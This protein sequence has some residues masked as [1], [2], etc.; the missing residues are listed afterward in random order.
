MGFLDVEGIGRT[1]QRTIEKI[2]EAQTANQAQTAN[3]ESSSR[4][5]ELRF[6]GAFARFR[7]ENNLAVQNVQ[8]Q[9]PPVD[10]DKVETVFN[11]TIE[12]DDLAVRLSDK[13][14][15]LNAAEKLQLAAMA[16]RSDRAE[17]LL[18]FFRPASPPNVTYD[19]QKQLATSIGAAYRQGI[20]TDSDLRQLAQR[21]GPEESARFAATLAQSPGNVNVGGVVEAYGRQA[22]ALGQSQA[23][24]LAFSSSE[25]LIRKDLPTYAD[26]SAAFNQVKSFVEGEPVGL[27]THFGYGTNPYMQSEY[28]Q[29]L[30]NYARLH[31]WGL[32]SNEEFDKL[33][34]TAGPRFVAESI[35]R[36]SNIAGDD[37][38]Y[39]ALK[40][41]GDAS[42]R[43]A[44]KTDGDK[45]H[46]WY[47]NAAMSFTQSPALI[48][49][50]LSTPAQR[51]AAFDLL[52][53]EL[54]GQRS[55]ARDAVKDEYN[56]YTLLRAPAMAQ[57]LA[58][59]LTAYPDE[60]INAKLTNSVG[61]FQGQADL[62]NLFES[63]LFSPYTSAETRSQI[64]R[65]VESYITREVGRANN[66]S[67]IIGNRL[68]GLLGVLE[69][70]TQKA[71]ANAQKPEEKSFIDKVSQDFAKTL[72]KTGAGALLK[73]TGPVGSLVG[74]F[75]LDQ[76]LD[77]I[78]EDK[79]P[80]ADQLGE[81]YIQQLEKSGVNVNL[82]EDLRNQYVN[83]LTK[84][85]TSLNELRDTAKGQRF[86]NIVDSSL[87]T[88][89]L[90]D[91]M[92]ITAGEVVR[93]YQLKGEGLDRA[94]NDWDKNFHYQG[95]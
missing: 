58:E 11:T 32:G 78:F 28:V 38:S 17:Q 50:N 61:N 27:V 42:R 95:F 90:M 72:L 69:V 51:M 92:R 59:L 82:G 19:Q 75:V 2:T 87:Q 53:H 13:F 70:S 80:S 43:M 14:T 45:Q 81:A 52:N 62:A 86:N 41:F 6:S 46:D 33:L 18:G 60:I 16:V 71:I 84:V 3:N 5:E 54:A 31:S 67:Q 29:G 49:S 76:V 94:I 63:T 44:A 21:L 89:Q 85:V 88:Q 47:V 79:P 68:G 8:R 73:P 77:K 10:M 40:M 56:Q 93:S 83:L 34:E 57:G 12:A 39:S 1:I 20:I 37:G 55:A 91:G 23:A 25:E 9:T 36:S 24:A 15:Y 22:K 64:Q 30:A 66:D 35:A 48:S 7:F 26:R 74:G 65:A 4:V